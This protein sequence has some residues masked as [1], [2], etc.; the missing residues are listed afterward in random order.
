MSA[1]LLVTLAAVL[2]FYNVSA[3][4]NDRAC[5]HQYRA[6][7]Q[8]TIFEGMKTGTPNSDLKCSEVEVYQ[9]RC[10]ILINIV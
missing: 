4:D 5:L 2:M 3:N 1:H 7:A 6:C 8:N 9:I 10:Q